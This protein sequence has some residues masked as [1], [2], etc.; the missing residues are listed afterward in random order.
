MQCPSPDGPALWGWT[1]LLGPFEIRGAERPVPL[2]EMDVNLSARA[3]S[4]VRKSD[5]L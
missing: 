2:P 3:G 1:G 4:D 5:D